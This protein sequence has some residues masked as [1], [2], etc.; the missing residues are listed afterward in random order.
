MSGS[1]A[2][3]ASL[4]EK[5]S[6]IHRFNRRVDEAQ[7]AKPSTKEWVGK[8][9]RRE[10]ASRC[11]IRLNNLS[12]DVILRYGDDLSDLLTEYPDDIVLA[13]AYHMFVGHQ[14]G[15]PDRPIDPIQVLTERAEWTDEWGTRW[16][17]A[18][19]G[20]GA[21]PKAVPLSDWS[22][23]DKYL[24][25]RMPDPKAPGRL[26]GALPTVQLHGES[27]YLAGMI[28]NALFERLHCL[29]GI[30]NTLEDLYASPRET[31]RL[32]LAAFPLPAGFP[33]ARW[34]SRTGRDQFA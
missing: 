23:L 4:D 15:G 7:H 32:Q 21:S 8:A 24:A 18:A 33:A 14:P 13:Q 20:T 29:H 6:L 30:E 3:T 11:P 31:E 28:P 25:H 16:E 22:E 34:P 12:Y 10:G 1:D 5:R 17:H 19:G 26:D 9:L 2:G 27:K